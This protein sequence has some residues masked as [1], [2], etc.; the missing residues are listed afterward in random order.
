MMRIFILTLSFLMFLSCLSSPTRKVVNKKNMVFIPGGWF[1]HSTSA[2]LDKRKKVYID[3]FYIDKYE[4]SNAD[5]GLFIKDGGYNKQ[6]YWLSDGWAFIKKNKVT[7]PRWWKAGRYNSG[8]RFA[9]YP[10]IGICW[11]EAD[12]YARWAGKR[13]P[14]EAEWEKASRGPTKRRFPWGNED[15]H[16][17][18]IYHANFETY[19]DG[20]M[21]SAPVNKFP[22]GKSPYGCFNMLGNVWEYTSSRYIKAYYKNIPVRNPRGPGAGTKRVVRGGSWFK[23][24]SY[25]ESF[26]RFGAVPTEKRYDDFGFRCAASAK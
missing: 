4:V 7:G 6:K 3:A 23:D 13:L 1:F 24:P 14:T 15:I 10:V 17:E 5:Y 21:Y 8:P 11:Y 16:Y 22:Q 18:I 9:A 2:G 20:F 12:A 25:Y 26:F 19:Q